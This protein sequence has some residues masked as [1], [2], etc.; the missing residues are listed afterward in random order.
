[1][2]PSAFKAKVI[3]RMQEADLSV[4]ELAQQIGVSESTLFRWRRLAGGDRVYA[5]TKKTKGRR[6]EDWSAEEKLA[7]VLETASLSEEELGAY[8]R[9]KGLH[10]VQLARW[11]QAMLGGLSA[12]SKQDAAAK[13]RIRE[14]EKELRRKDKALAEAAALLVLK[15][16]A[17][18]I[19]GDEDASTAPSSET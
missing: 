12:R 17:Q 4:Q 5:M 15:K 11:R 18:E 2:Y 9:R 16:K 1:M 6:P 7:A 3:Q 13:R 19:W 10:K 8:L 14:L